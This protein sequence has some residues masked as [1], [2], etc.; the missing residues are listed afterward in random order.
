MKERQMT[1]SKRWVAPVLT[2]FLFALMLTVPLAVGST[3]SDRSEDPNHTLTYTKNKL[4]WDTATNIDVATGVAQL[5]LFDAIYENVESHDGGNIIAPGTEGYNI[6][7]LKND[8]PGSVKFT[9][10]LYAIKTDDRL[11]VK[12]FLTGE[13][14]IDTDTYVLPDG[15]QESSVI[16][17][18]S[19]KLSRGQ[20]CDFDIHWLWNYEV[21]ELQDVI[22]TYF[23]TQAAQRTADD[24]TVGLYIVVEDNTNYGGYVKPEVPKTGD[25]SMMTMY[26]ILMGV[27]VVLLLM[28]LPRRRK[29]NDRG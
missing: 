8:A 13:N 21:D 24:M 19:G 17:A 11:P 29:E 2:I 23:G 12:A 16:K 18:V 27:S 5:D 3:Y 26:F 22:D 25:D 10:V 7:R 6:V 15:V 9:A 4:T 14:L 1:K 20:I 28:Y